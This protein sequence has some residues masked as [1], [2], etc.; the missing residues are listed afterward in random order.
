CCVDSQRVG[1]VSGPNGLE[2]CEC[3]P[4][5]GWD[6]LLRC[7]VT[8]HWR[9]IDQRVFTWVRRCPV[10]YCV[11]AGMPLVPRFGMTA[12]RLFGCFA[13]GVVGVRDQRGEQGVPIREVPVQR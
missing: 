8:R 11:T 2:Q 9:T 13:H 7:V 4:A 10:T 12:D 6:G 5:R 1:C 3:D